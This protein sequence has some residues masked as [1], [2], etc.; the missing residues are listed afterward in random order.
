M[1]GTHGGKPNHITAESKL[2]LF[3]LKSAAA[4][5]VKVKMDRNTFI[6]FNSKTALGLSNSI[7][8]SSPYCSDYCPSM[9]IKD[10]K[11]IDT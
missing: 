9:L 4:W 11:F 1:A 3:K 10:S 2:P 5:G 8:G 7:F 6:G